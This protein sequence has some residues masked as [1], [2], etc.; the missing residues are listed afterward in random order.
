MKEVGGG[1]GT[2]ALGDEI[3]NVWERLLL[4]FLT[5][6]ADKD[7]IGESFA[8]LSDRWTAPHCRRADFLCSTRIGSLCGGFGR[9][10]MVWLD[11]RH[12]I[13]GTDIARRVS[14]MRWIKTDSGSGWGGWM[15]WQSELEFWRVVRW[16]MWTLNMDSIRNVWLVC[17][18]RWTARL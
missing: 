6:S 10:W 1:K 18:W 5:L 8:W 12:G 17:T 3:S 11:H 9:G 2:A 4:L 7:R 16:V 13:S 14:V 15:W